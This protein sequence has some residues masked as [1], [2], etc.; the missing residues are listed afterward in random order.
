MA[1]V[2]ARFPPIGGSRRSRRKIENCAVAE[3]NKKL[4]R[5][6]DKGLCVSSRIQFRGARNIEWELDR[7]SV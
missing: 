1:I 2:F 4:G 6:E 3:S 7:A 5:G